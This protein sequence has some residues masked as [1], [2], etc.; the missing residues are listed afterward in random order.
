[1]YSRKPLVKFEA[2]QRASLVSTLTPE[3]DVP[4]T[5]VEEETN[6]EIV[7]PQEGSE[8]TK[9]QKSK[10][11]EKTKHSRQ[12]IINN[13]LQ[14]KLPGYKETQKISLTKLIAYLPKKNLKRAA[15]R[16]LL[17]SGIQ[18]STKKKRKSKRTAPTALFNDG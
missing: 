4:P 15:K 13:Q 12:V 1:M 6:T 8:E 16:A 3:E 17:A 9:T 11:K 18:G 2:V 7:T 14:I 10:N 5:P